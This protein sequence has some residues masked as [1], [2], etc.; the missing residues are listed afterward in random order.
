MA[1]DLS[2]NAFLT[3]SLE[4]LLNSL[5]TSGR[6]VSIILRFD[7]DP[8]DDADV[9]A[10][11]QN[12]NSGNLFRVRGD[13]DGTD[14][15]FL[16]TRMNGGAT[17]SL[18]DGQTALTFGQWHYATSRFR[19]G[20]PDDRTIQTFLF[21]SE[22]PYTSTV[23]RGTSPLDFTVFNTLRLGDSDNGPSVVAL[24][25]GSGDPDGYH[26]HI[27]AGNNPADY[28]FGA[29]PDCSLIEYIPLNRT[30]AGAF[31][32][33][34]TEAQGTVGSDYNQFVVGGTGGINW[35]TV[36]EPWSGAVTPEAAPYT[37]LEVSDTG[38]R[39]RARLTLT[40]NSW[41]NPTVDF[42]DFSA[43]STLGYG[44][45]GI[46]AAAVENVSGS[47]LDLVLTPSRT[48]HT[49]ERL[50]LDALVNAVVDD[51]G[52]GS[53][54]LSARSIDASG[55]AAPPATAT[56]FSR[57]RCWIKFNSAAPVSWFADEV[58]VVD[59]PGSLTITEAFPAQTTEGGDIIHGIIKNMQR[60]ASG[61]ANKQGW[62]ERL[63]TTGTQGTWDATLNETVPVS[64]TAN[65]CIVKCSSQPGPLG[66]A[67]RQLSTVQYLICHFVSEIPANPENT[68]SPPHDGFDGTSAR[69]QPT[70]D[71]DAFVADQPSRNS[72]AAPPS[73][74][75][76]TTIERFCQPCPA[77]AFTDAAARDH[78]PRNF[79]SAG[80][81]YGG[82]RTR[83][84]E[85]A[86]MH[87]HGNVA[88]T[89]Q[90]KQIAAFL[91]S[92]GCSI[93]YCFTQSGV[94][95]VTTPGAQDLGWIGAVAVF[96]NRDGNSAALATLK[97]DVGMNELTHLVRLTASNVAGMAPHDTSISSSY[98]GDNWWM[99]RRRNV[100]AVNG[101]IVTTDATGSVVLWT[102]YDDC[103]MINETQG[104]LEVQVTANSRGNPDFTLAGG[105]GTQVNDVVYFRPAPAAA[106]VAG[107]VW[108]S[109]FA[110][111]RG[112][113]S[114]GS[115]NQT[116][117]DLERFYCSLM[118]LEQEGIVNSV[119]G[120][121]ELQE[122]V[123]N[124]ATGTWPTAANPVS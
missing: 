86:V 52:N 85:D 44:E 19:L 13:T 50:E 70:V 100:S 89:A 87:L 24:A 97:D 75:V 29:D 113:S 96:L 33:S 18:G 41:N 95:A 14:Q 21:D 71:L 7:A 35:N 103:V 105:H 16:S 51:D 34:H 104:D 78:Y 58:G 42:N 82:E 57:G 9:I 99:Y 4:G 36:A 98:T 116:Y 83:T 49:N 93:Y 110:G 15:A 64:V 79:T 59:D 74:D 66:I 48:L 65:D 22:S 45:I 53:A 37:D 60:G 31:S 124:R 122:F 17:D 121:R 111:V 119:Q 109:E 101:N 26:A 1:L 67:P 32:T 108:W 5:D 8:N 12:G 40:S 2:T 90:K 39:V 91:L 73:E 88:T 80:G 3:Q 77:I 27:A 62:D 72:G 47:S 38:T 94:S 20:S 54:A 55:G 102:D 115:N 106:L 25:I 84:I 114:F 117:I 23:D 63:G 107:V 56:G 112:G 61:K 28:S 43:F 76:A 68:I 92:A 123:R 81:G 10:L 6:W 11:E 46:T 120:G 30:T 69:P 118:L